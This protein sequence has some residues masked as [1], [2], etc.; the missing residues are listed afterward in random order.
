MRLARAGCSRSELRLPRWGKVPQA[1]EAPNKILFFASRKSSKTY[2]IKYFILHSDCKII[3]Y[4]GYLPNLIRIEKYR[5][6]FREDFLAGLEN[7]Y[8]IWRLIRHFVPP[9]PTGEGRSVGCEHSSLTIFVQ[10]DI[11]PYFIGV[12]QQPENPRKNGGDF[13]HYFYFPVSTL[14]K[15]I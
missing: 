5:A 13:L 15:S 11:L 4:D 14:M 10:F 9:S 6:G 1:D 12:C 7:R 8:L 3:H 2:P